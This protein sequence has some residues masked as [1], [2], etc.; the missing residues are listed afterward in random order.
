MPFLLSTQEQLASFREAAPTGMAMVHVDTC[1]S[2][3]VQDHHN[4]DGECLFGVYVD[5]SMTVEAVKAGLI[6]EV[7]S[8]GDRLPDEI[9]D[10][11]VRAAIEETFADADM[12]AIFAPGADV[13]ADDDDDMS[14]SCQAWFVLTWETPIEPD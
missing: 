3:Y 6:D 14:E 8:T 13:P 4:R 12:S 1:L 5:G 7:R 11:M 9:T 10:E 2:C